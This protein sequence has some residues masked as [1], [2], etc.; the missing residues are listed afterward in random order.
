MPTLPALDPPSEDEDPVEAILTRCLLA[1]AEEREGELERACRENPELAR[2]LKTRAA[3]LDALGLLSPPASAEELPPQLGDFRPLERLGAGGM[4]VVFRAEQVSLAREV[5]LKLVR[6][7]YLFFPGARERFRREVEAVARLKHPGIVPVYS[8]GEE[9]GLPYFAM[10]LVEGCTLAELLEELGERDPAA[11]D[12]ADLVQAFRR[13]TRADARRLEESFGGRSWVEASLEIARQVAEALQHAHERGIL[14]RDVKPSNIMLDAGGRVMLLDFGLTS[15]QDG[16]RVTRTGSRL[17]TLHYMSPEQ[18]RGEELDKGADVYALGASLYELLTLRPPFQ[19][20]SALAIQERILAGG[21]PPPRSLNRRVGRDADVV[22]RTAFEPDRARRYASAELLARDLANALAHRP[23]IARRPGPLLAA[24]RWARRHPTTSVGLALGVLLAAGIPSALYLQQVGHASELEAANRDLERSLE[25]EREAHAEEQRAR[26]D[27]ESTLDVLGNVLL[28]ATPER[29]QGRPLVVE[30]ILERGVAAVP[31]LAQRP[32]VQGVYLRVLGDAFRRIGRL[33]RAIELLR[34][35][36]Q[37][38]RE[39]GAERSWPLLLALNSLG[40][41][42]QL[43]GRI[44][45]AIDVFEEALEGCLATLPSDPRAIALFHNNLGGALYDRRDYAGAVEHQREALALYLQETPPDLEQVCTAR[46]NLALLVLELGNAEEARELADQALATVREPNALE[47]IVQAQILNSI[48][49]VQDRLGGEEQS[50]ALRREALTTL[51][52]IYAKG[53]LYLAA[54]LY[55][56]GRQLAG[57]GRE[58]E[59]LEL[60]DEAVR[61]MDELGLADHP[62]AARYRAE[63]DAVVRR[64]DQQ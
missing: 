58:D 16:Q 10:E 47:P 25:R 49:I 44:D 57:Q 31:L 29:L 48:A 28:D 33:D 15:G 39:T 50:E 61:M 34:Q 6:P 42:L 21:A 35:S 27:A 8:V 13:R 53:D 59:A 64:I 18:V 37:L 63:L 12:G 54:T 23:V 2:E 3:A 36:A 60:L 24:S 32:G 45:E 41:A 9:R 43:R 11:L 4:G 55:N 19:G 26:E 17:G 38:E 7:D 30:D 62:N 1:P 51:R 5:A 52:G 56:L 20:A 14:H 40:S 22:C 46:S